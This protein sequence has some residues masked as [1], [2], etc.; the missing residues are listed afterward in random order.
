MKNLELYAEV[1]HQTQTAIIA[2][3]SIPAIITAD[4]YNNPKWLDQRNHERDR[5]DDGFFMGRYA[6]VAADLEAGRLIDPPAE[7]YE[8]ASAITAAVT[9]TQGTTRRR[10]RIDG[11]DGSLNISRYLDD[12]DD[13]LFTRRRRIAT[14]SPI[15]NLFGSFC[16]SGRQSIKRFHEAAAALTAASDALTRQG[17]SVN[18]YSYMK[19][20][21]TAYA[22]TKTA[23]RI[24]TAGTPA[25][26]SQIWTYTR[27]EVSRR[28]YFMC[29]LCSIQ[30]YFD[31]PHTS[32]LGCPD[33]LT[34]EEMRD[35]S[36]DGRNIHITA[37]AILDAK[38]DPERLAS[39]I[40]AAIDAANTTTT[41]QED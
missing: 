21:I 23:Y 19:S 20:R 6:D 4:D 1:N 2:P 24:K 33:A 5:A 22:I 27:P 37:R 16:F 12:R 35:I 38:G 40:N 15:V 39:F 41:T 14:P 10:R 36:G 26:I 28:I 32:S 3:E 25:N 34:P 31:A 30:D 18:I 8:M 7:V 11:D 17:Y 29:S 13:R 9:T